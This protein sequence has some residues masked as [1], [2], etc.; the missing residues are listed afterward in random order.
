MLLLFLV[1]IFLAMYKIEVGINKEFMSIK[2]TT[3]INGLFILIVF[4]R[5]LAQYVNYNTIFD[6]PMFY[7]DKH[8][9]QF[10]VVTFLFYSGFGIMESIE[11]KDN[12]VQKIPK[13][14]ILK[15]WIQFTVCVFI[16]FI[17]G[18][19]YGNDYS[20]TF[21]IKS[22]LGWESFGNS[23]WYIFSM[24]FL[25]LFTWVA[26][27]FFKKTQW[28][29]ILFVFIFTI[30]FIIVM[31]RLKEPYWY[32]TVL[33]YPAGMLYSH[34]KSEVDKILKSNIL[35]IIGLLLS[36]IIT[37]G[38][39]QYRNF[40]IWIYECCGIMFAIWI[41]FMTMRISIKNKYTYWLGKNLFGLY[42]LQRIPMM[43][44]NRVGL[45]VGHPYL[46]A[47]LCFGFMLVLGYLFQLIMSKVRLSGIL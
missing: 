23:N 8:I 41:T 35:W 45:G 36:S 47:L 33:C 16:Y 32:N 18:L 30:L 17:L 38:L 39:Y 40:N 31:G 24:L 15:T 9:G 11:K 37:Y 22:F 34:L 4:F 19:F 42:I 20:L 7:I 27:S 6:F 13:K 29:A 21:I 43:V 44:L 5:H 14:R 2:S 12:Y 46:Y 10:L 1:I 25:W 26:F 3:C 28:L